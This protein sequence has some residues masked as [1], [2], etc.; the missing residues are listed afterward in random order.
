MYVIYP[1]T[2]SG[3]INQP[4]AVLAT[5]TPSIIEETPKNAELYDILKPVCGCESAGKP[6][7]EPRQ[8]EIDG[9]TVRYGRVNNLDKGMCQI[10]LH[11]HEAQS[12]KLGF[13][14]MTADGNI[15]YA[16][17]LYDRDGLQPWSA[18]KPCW[19]STVNN[20]INP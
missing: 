13:D 9:I 5:S 8:Y 7:L 20:L 10:N 3:S 1:N 2:I 6:Y 16:N 18:S 15:K 12:E 11:Y 19:Q 17:W 14:V 4:E